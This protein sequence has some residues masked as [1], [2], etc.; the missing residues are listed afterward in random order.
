MKLKELG[1]FLSGSLFVG[2]IW[3][4]FHFWYTNVIWLALLLT[5]CF[6]TTFTMS[7]YGVIGAIWW[8]IRTLYEKYTK[9]E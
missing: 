4:M 3:F 2:M 5:L 9:E 8:L 7:L 6:F 1:Y